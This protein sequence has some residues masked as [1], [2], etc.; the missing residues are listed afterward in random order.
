MTQFAKGVKRVPSPV[1]CGTKLTHDGG[2]AVIDGGSLAFC[3]EVE[4]VGNRPR[5]CDL[6]DV[7][8]LESCLAA[9]NLSLPDVGALAVDGWVRFSDG[10]AVVDVECGGEHSEIPVAGY[11]ERRDA[12]AGGEPLYAVTGALPA[13]GGAVDYRSYPHATGHLLSAY[14]TSPFARDQRPS[15]ALIWDGGM[16]ATLYQVDPRTR[17]VRS[18]GVV[19]DITGALYPT[20]AACL[21]A[22]ELP[23]SS[24]P[25]A[26]LPVSGKAMALA[27]TGQADEEGIAECARRFAAYG[28]TLHRSAGARWSR[29]V[30][31]ALRELGL[32]DPDMIA[33]M[34]EFICRE[35]VASLTQRLA[36]LGGRPSVLCFAGGCA[37]NI[38]W[39]ARLRSCGLF[40]DVWVPPF[41]NDSGSAIGTACAEMIAR[42]GPMQ[43]DWDV[44]RGPGLIRDGAPLPGWTVGPAKV[45]DVA[46]L[47]HETGE[48]VVVLTGRA[49][50][51]PRALGHR[52]VLAPAVSRQMRDRLNTA[53]QREWYRPVAPICLEEAAPKIF[54]PGGRDPYM[55]FDHLVRP[56]WADVIPA[57]VHADGSARLQ[58]IDATADPVIAELLREYE[59]LSG[60]PVL[61]NTSANFKGLGFFPD[62]ASAMRWGE[63]GFVWSDGRLYR[64][65]AVAADEG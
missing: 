60:L 10:A 53:K 12:R 7:S 52:S 61:C 27:G 19:L 25:E 63:T 32:R 6:A 45:D 8:L 2:V 33:C 55:L 36:P 46:R 54:D 48:P 31:T 22:F 17:S 64:K 38:K 30:I 3:I 39:N 28:R 26:Y 15:L 16:P 44:Y 14:C 21:P 51:G 62:A 18:L 35:L 40:E 29:E 41:P 11:D 24:D 57:V 1:V 43:L 59:A 42:G 49:E 58:T 4:K 56:E 23:S 50:L 20:F 13:P 9:E 65:Q 34:Q 5:H 37:L 47:L